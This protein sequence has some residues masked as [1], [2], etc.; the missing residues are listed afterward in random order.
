[1]L[2][3]TQ[4]P[5]TSSLTCCS[6]WQDGI[7]S[8][9]SSSRISSIMLLSYGLQLALL[10]SSFPHFRNFFLQCSRKHSTSPFRHWL[11]IWRL[12]VR[13]SHR[14]LRHGNASHVAVIGA[15]E[16]RDVDRD[17]VLVQDLALVGINPPGQV[18]QDVEIRPFEDT[19][20]DVGD[21][22]VTEV[23]AI[24]RRVNPS[25]R[26]PSPSDY[27]H[28]PDELTRSQSPHR[29]FRTCRELRPVGACLSKYRPAWEK[30]TQDPWV[31]DIISNGYAPQFTLERPPLTRDWRRF[32]S[33]T[34]HTPPA[35][36]TLLQE[37]LDEL[38]VKEA[39]E[40]VV[41]SQSLGF[42]SHMFLV[43]KKNTSKLRPIINLK[44][45]NG[46][47]DIPSFQMETTMS[48][49]AAVQP[50]DWATSLDLTDAYFHIPIAPWFRKYLRIVVNG[51]LF[52]YRALPFGLS[53][54]PLVFTKMLEPLAVFLHS[55]GIV[56]HR[57]LDD[58]LIRCQSQQLCQEWTLFVLDLLFDLGLGV[59]LEKSDLVASQIFKYIGIL[60]LTL[61]GLMRPPE[62]RVTKIQA[63]GRELLSQLSPAS[64]WMSF[65]G[66]LGSAEKQVPFGR[67]HIRPIHFC[68]RRQFRLGVHLL[69]RL[70]Q[71]DSAAVEAI[72]W[73]CN[74][75]NLERGQPLGQFRPDLVLYTDACL[76]SWGGWS[77]DFQ[78]SGEWT[79]EESRLSINALE[80]LA[81]QRTLQSSDKDWDGL[82]I[83]VASDNSTTVA[84]VN[85]QGGTKSLI[86]LDIAY[87][88][89]H[90]VQQKGITLRARHIPGRL[91]RVADLLSRR[92][93]IVNT[94]WTLCPR[95]IRDIWSIWGTPHI[96]LMATLYNNQ[97]PVYVSPFPDL[98]AQAVD[99]MSL[100]WDRMDAYIFPPW[101]MIQEV[102]IK[103]Q[104]HQ[105]YLTAI[106]PRWPSRPWFP[107]LLQSLIDYPRRLPLLHDIITMPHNGRTHGQIQSLDLHVCR[108]S[109]TSY[110]TKAFR[111]RCRSESQKAVEGIPPTNFTIPS[112]RN[113]LF[114]VIDGAW[115]HSKPLYQ[116]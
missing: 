20:E 23:A 62:D 81:V 48:V 27:L 21:S 42:Y 107:L 90:L 6:L 103:L 71:A 92:D 54:S 14:S 24:P 91:N 4:Q 65:I 116:M 31:L 112:G 11:T 86:C 69:D 19:P 33:I 38:L 47:L 72:T 115:I 79:R 15:T 111:Q 67:I 77:P 41:D 3:A 102:L 53:T 87:D 88:L 2:A 84:Y 61:L 113:S 52:Q 10:L 100:S 60:F 1:M 50:G 105:C 32:E 73:W 94:E 74:E 40:P 46:F 22:V 30:I 59:S 108:L 44:R 43:T 49:A 26:N 106:L 56:F 80:L 89:F 75:S 5:F 109:S 96:D 45:L 98:Q 16:V 64:Q 55:R 104:T 12:G 93:D 82:K 34:H 78:V 85:N 28:S 63:L 58:F 97:L 76:K 18:R 83:L 8:L 101:A 25:Q 95:V 66:L 70:I 35:Q 36:A 57:Y 39:I 110:V 51:K 13:E 37:Y 99:A 114:G 9:P 7:L 29:P 17:V 68:L